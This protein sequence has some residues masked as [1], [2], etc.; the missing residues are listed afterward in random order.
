MTSTSSSLDRALQLAQSKGWYTIP[1][2]P[3]GKNP[4]ARDYYAHPS[5]SPKDIRELWRQS[6]GF[7]RSTARRVAEGNVQGLD[8]DFVEVIEETEGYADLEPN[9][10]VLLGHSGLVVVDVDT[11]LQMDA[12]QALCEREGYD[13]GAPTQRS[14][15]VIKRTGE[16]KHDGQGHFFYTLPA[17]LAEHPDL[18]SVGIKLKVGD[19]TVECD[20][21]EERAAA[22]PDLMTGKRYVLIAPS[23]RTEGAYVLTP[24]A[25]VRPL[26][27][28]L[29]APLREHLAGKA[30]VRQQHAERAAH[31]VRDDAVWAWDETVDWTDLLEDWTEEGGEGNCIVL[32]HPEAQ[33]GRSAVAH[34]VDCEHTTISALIAEGTPPPITFYTSTLPEWVSDALDTTTGG[35]TVGKL[36]LYAFKYHHGDIANARRSLGLPLRAPTRAR[37]A[38][39]PAAPKKATGWASVSLAPS[40]TVTDLGIAP[41]PVRKRRVALVDTPPAPLTA[42]QFTEPPADPFTEPASTVVAE[43]VV[44]PMTPEVTS[45]ENAQVETPKTS[46][47]TTRNSP[48]TPKAAPIKK[49]P[50]KTVAAKEAEVYDPAWDAEFTEEVPTVPTWEPAPLRDQ[51]ARFIAAHA[52]PTPSE[53]WESL[54]ARELRL[55]DWMGRDDQPEKWDD[56]DR[57]K[58]QDRAD[59]F[60]I[61]HASIADLAEQLGVTPERARAL[62]RVLIPTAAEAGYVIRDRPRSDPLKF[63]VPPSKPEESDLAIWKVQ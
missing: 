8:T 51:T 30:R 48:A 60:G 42:D 55:S 63:Q 59:L 29:A 56:R 61:R 50:T 19:P 28:F 26:P 18:N 9:I 33:A 13:P 43:K 40:V 62:V 4:A 31:A 14:P 39:A 54:A 6:R 16:V 49:T 47:K 44:S 45:A 15:G 32:A 17:D 52:I 46:K 53:V 7:I 22:V 35:S 1:V 3:L 37:K 21:D 10:A 27:D 12:W 23:T 57:A 5:L 25:T 2:H 36:K 38:S 58:R 34:T 20:T 41:R 24:G 11:T